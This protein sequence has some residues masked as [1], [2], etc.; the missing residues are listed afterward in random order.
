M[1]RNPHIRRLIRKGFTLLEL[2]L[3]MSIGMVVAGLVLA[4]FNQQLAFLRIFDVQNFLNE[5]AP[6]VSMHVSRIVGNADRYRLHDN[7]EDALLNRNPRIENAPVLLMNFR[8]P[9]GSTRATIL[10]FETR[11]EIQ[12]LYHHVVPLAGDIPEPGWFVTDRVRNVNFSI[13]EG[14]LRMRLTGRNGEQITYSGTMQQ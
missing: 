14:I 12:A 11:N 2:T 6:L 13:E 9:D 3:A 1:T 10:A 8:Q 5:E 7:L 4:M